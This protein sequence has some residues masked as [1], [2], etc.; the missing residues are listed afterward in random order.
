MS[1][2]LF[3]QIRKVDE[4]KRLVFG[5]LADDTVDKADE[6]M[7]YDGSK[8][9]FVKWSEA[10]AKDTGGASVGNLRAMHGKVAAGKFTEIIY[11]DAAKTIDVVAKVV[12]D[13]EWKKVVEGVYTGFSIGGSYVGAKT[14]EKMDDGREIKRYVASPTEG[15]LVDR[16][17][18]K[19]ALFFEVQK[20]DGVVAKVDFVNQPIA[21]EADPLTIKGSADEVA[22]LAKYMNDNGL[23]MADVLAKVET[24]APVAAVVVQTPEELAKIADGAL[25][26]GMW[27][28]SSMASVIGSLQ[29]LQ[30]DAAYQAYFN[31]GSDMAKRIGA[32]ISLC[33]QVLKEMVD[34]EIA[35]IGED[36]TVM[37]LAEKI[38]ALAKFEG[39]PLLV[40]VKVGARNNKADADRIQA[41]HD[42]SNTLGAACADPA[43]DK[44][45]PAG[46]LAK[47]DDV[48]AEERLAKALAPMQKLLD[49]QTVVLNKALA[50]VAMLKAQ[51]AP[52]TVTLRAITKAE[53]VGSDDT[54][55][56]K[57][58]PVV[59]TAGVTHEPAS[60]IK[61]LHRSGGVPLHG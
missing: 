15:S 24:P 19:N 36:A 43:A 29:S 2:Q 4:E 44:T 31:A 11:D 1:L 53:D 34:A 27:S 46:D 54:P 10:I 56:A 28:C 23:T 6:A 49:D 48:A 20:A 22:K 41:I 37:E 40:L 21:V 18:N 52:T 7:D 25:R 42:H 58:A 3:A 30:S 57:V 45:A 50:D 61:S 33:G 35:D 55:I 8:P 14:V 38:G 17:C 13:N 51:P 9:H 16:P 39:D 47:L 26:K 59:D 5:R 60:L 32:C 12:D